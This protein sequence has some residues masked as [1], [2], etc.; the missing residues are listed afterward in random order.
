MTYYV[1]FFVHAICETTSPGASR[2]IRHYA[3]S[4]QTTQR[5]M[6]WPKAGSAN[7]LATAS[8][9]TSGAGLGFG[10]GIA[11]SI[12]KAFCCAGVP[13]APLASAGEAAFFRTTVVLAVEAAVTASVPLKTGNRSLFRARLTSVVVPPEDRAVPSAC[14]RWSEN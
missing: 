6:I 12:S 2:R 14:M 8:Q 3:R 9:A 4:I 7:G 5:P 11:S 1:L 13:C 10:V